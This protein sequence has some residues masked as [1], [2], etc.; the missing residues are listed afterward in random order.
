MSSLARWIGTGTALLAAGC[1]SVGATPLASDERLARTGLGPGDRVA[2]RLISYERC[3][4]ADPADHGACESLPEPER[5]AARLER[6]L[7]RR[8][9][10]ARLQS[11]G[12]PRYL[13]EVRARNAEGGF[14]TGG[15]SG[16]GW[17]IGRE[18]QRTTDLEVEVRDARG[19]KLGR[20]EAKAYGA[21]GW[22][23]LFLLNLFPV[24]LIENARTEAAACKAMAGAVATFL[25][26]PEPQKWLPES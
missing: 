8:L 11:G 5:F 19:A 17:M 16:L 18:A 4:T 22:G 15:A 12:A 14:P 10:E 1:Y 3:E 26:D 20:I 21:S 13:L 24:P 7:A 9:G 6:C 23:V 25:E 2:S